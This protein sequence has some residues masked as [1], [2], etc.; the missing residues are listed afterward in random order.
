M[1][2]RR[3]IIN[4]TESSSFMGDGSHNLSADV[5]FSLSSDENQDADGNNDVLRDKNFSGSKKPNSTL[6]TSSP[7]LFRKETER[8]VSPLADM[9]EEALEAGIR[10]RYL[11][12]FVGQ[13]ALREHLSILI[14]AARQRSQSVDHILFAGPPGLGKTTLASIVANEMGTKIQ[15]TSGPVL[16]RGGDLAA[17]L[18]GLAPGDV[19]FIDEIHRLSRA[20]EEVLYPAM[21]DQAIDI[22]IGKGPSAQAI[23]LTLPSFTLV[24]AT[25]RTGLVTGPLRDRFGFVAR[26]DHYGIDELRSIV[27]RTARILDVEIDEEGAWEIAK[28]SRGTPRLAIR[29]LRRVR[30][31]VQVRGQGVITEESAMQ[32]CEIFGVDKLG[33]DH[34]DRQILEVLCLRFEGRPVGLSTLAVSLGEE[35]DTLED[36]YE[37]YLLRAG[38]IL[39]TPRGRV[40]SLAAWRHLGIEPPQSQLP[41]I[42]EDSDT[43]T[44]GQQS[45]TEAN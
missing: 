41:Y 5:E 36:V 37:P 33:L 20:V 17:I 13:S 44:G 25:T 31:F 32:G 30:D 19:L 14:E 40:P 7:D 35:P 38:L 22:V 12:D 16:A 8:S 23:R 2:P 39:R 9:P 27:F 24:G 42:L 34:L 4:N 1:S 15:V 6:N 45:L 11:G 3:E 21:E 43:Q 29:L 18:S 28:R 10:P 26:L